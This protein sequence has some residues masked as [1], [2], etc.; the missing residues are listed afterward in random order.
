MYI[1]T[2]LD[3]AK[4]F[5]RGSKNICCHP[6]SASVST[7]L[8]K[9]IRLVS[10]IWWLAELHDGIAL[11]TF[12]CPSLLIRLGTLHMPL[13]QVYVPSPQP[14]IPTQPNLPIMLAFNSCFI[15]HSPLWCFCHENFHCN[16]TKFTHLHFLLFMSFL[17]P[18][19]YYGT[20]FYK[21]KSVF[22][23][24]QILDLCVI[25]WMVVCHMA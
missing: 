23:M 16:R 19:S 10:A 13:P 3:S 24:W 7:S 4:P 22:G 1:W 17:L 2:L 15:K 5:Q 12:A 21:K 20:Y 14:P 9:L 11:V 6:W 25:S 18:R 8:A